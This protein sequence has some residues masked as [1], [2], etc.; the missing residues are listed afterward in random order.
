[1]YSAIEAE[2]PIES[3]SATTINEELLS[4]LGRAQRLVVCGQAKSHCCN[5]TVR[6]IVKYSFGKYKRN[7]DTK[8]MDPPVVKP[9]PGPSALTLENIFLLED[10]MSPVTG[11]EAPGDAFFTDMKDI[12]LK[13]V[14]STDKD[15]WDIATLP[16]LSG[17]H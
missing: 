5:Y 14:K 6:D 1:M 11:Y 8:L 3:D 16:S 9:V 12:G 10:G 13:I 15:L 17:N 4:A 7:K 2:V